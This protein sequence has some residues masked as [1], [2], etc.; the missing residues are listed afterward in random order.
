MKTWLRYGKGRLE[1]DLPDQARVI[2]TP[3]TQPLPDARDAISRALEDPIGCEAFSVLV[4]KLKSSEKV[5]VVI[6]DITRPV[7]NQIILEPILAKLHAAGVGLDRITILIATGMHRPST[8]QEKVE[9][10]GQRIAA[11][12]RIVDHKADDAD[13]LLPLGVSTPRGQEVW[14]D[15]EYMQA[16]LKVVTGF[17]EPHMMAGYSGGRKAVCPGLVNLETIQQFH[18]AQILAD[19]NSAACVLQEN[20][21][22]QEALAVARAAGIDFL[23]NVVV[24]PDKQVLAVVS[25]HFE[26]AHTQGVEWLQRH[27]TISDAGRYDIVITCGGGYPLDTTFY[28]A[29]KGMVLAEPLTKPDGVMAVAASCT[30]KI[31][32]RGYEQIMF[33]WKDDWPGFLDDI[34]ARREVQRDQWELQVQCRVLKKIGKQ[35]LLFV[36]DGIDV[37]TL[38]KLNV[39]P[40]SR[41]TNKT[42]NDPQE[43]TQT[44]IDQLLADSP[45]ASW[46]VIPDGPY[47]AVRP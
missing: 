26:L 31:G 7:P 28:Q 15:R 21:C 27:C 23:L 22:H 45:G 5:V 12:Y 1:L 19:P 39:T 13:S 43:M 4:N 44:L 29:V 47:I 11:K 8:A 30:E 40:A 35:N 16:D 17:I 38:A 18:G 25:G 10:L 37:Q 42:T 14:V 34:L 41:R 2:Q 6:S 46:A 32:S 36:T 33:R 24:N 20:P 3:H 9:L